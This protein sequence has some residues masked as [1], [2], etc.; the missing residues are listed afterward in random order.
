[1]ASPITLEQLRVMVDIVVGSIGSAPMADMID[2]KMRCV[3]KVFCEDFDRRNNVPARIRQRAESLEASTS[4]DPRRVAA[5]AADV[6]KEAL[7]GKLPSAV[8][9]HFDFAVDV[10]SKATMKLYRK[11]SCIPIAHGRFD[12]AWCDA[13]GCSFNIWKF[14]I[15]KVA[16]YCQEK[17]VKADRLLKY[18]QLVHQRDPAATP[19][20]CLRVATHVAVRGPFKTY[21]GPAGYRKLTSDRDN[22]AFAHTLLVAL[23]AL[24]D[25]GI[26]F[27]SRFS[28]PLH[29]H[30]CALLVDSLRGQC[31]PNE[32]VVWF[33]KC[34]K[35]VYLM[36]SIYC[37]VRRENKDWK[38]IDG[39]IEQRARARYLMRQLQLIA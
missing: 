11:L 18:I 38:K 29:A 21:L 13:F 14:N 12:I 17:G 27:T 22:V 39:V 28:A 9:A 5:R 2:L 33:N 6:R 31:F 10:S 3:G 24:P 23:P 15:W 16:R 1:M 37:G 25:A 35:A 32:A 8:S 36:N 34:K 19:V 20:E 26:V 7:K 30:A 4:W